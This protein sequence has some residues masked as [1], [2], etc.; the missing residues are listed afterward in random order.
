ML[1]SYLGKAKDNFQSPP[2]QNQHTPFPASLSF[3]AKIPR[4]PP[5]QLFLQNII[6]SLQRRVRTMFTIIKDLNESE[7]THLGC[8]GSNL[9]EAEKERFVRN[10]VHLGGGSVVAKSLDFRPSESLKNA[11]SESFYPPKL[12]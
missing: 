7:L 2:L 5:L 4:H 3:L 12:S 9:Q 11:L 8:I 1:F 10:Q 6:P